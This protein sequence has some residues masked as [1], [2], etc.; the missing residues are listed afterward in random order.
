MGASKAGL[1]GVFVLLLIVV[2]TVAAAFMIYKAAY[3]RKI[4]RRL[5]E[6][7]EAEIKPMMSPVKFVVITLLSALGALFLLW[8]ILLAVFAADKQ[9]MVHYPTLYTIDESLENSPLSRNEYGEIKG[10]RHYTKEYEKVLLD[11]YIQESFPGPF[12]SVMISVKS[13]ESFDYGKMKA[14]VS[15]GNK[16]RTGILYGSRE[17]EGGLL[18]LDNGGYKGDITFTCDLFYDKNAVTMG[19]DVSPDESC[20]LDLSIKEAGVVACPQ[21]GIT[22]E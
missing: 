8:I 6:G 18:V 1:I 21:L 19:P 4:N 5:A 13:R 17:E 14:E 2:L 20:R 7:R 15:F 22:V 9:K 3:K 11:V 12:P 10:Y 16:N